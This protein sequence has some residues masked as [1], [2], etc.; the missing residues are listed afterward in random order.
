M[1]ILAREARRCVLACAGFDP[2]PLMMGEICHL[3]D[4]D[5]QPC[6]PAFLVIDYDG[7]GLIVRRHGFPD[8]TMRR[9]QVCR[10]ILN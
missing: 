2:T 7:D 5:G 3:A 6:G 4:R 8:L 10:P 9:D 1:Q